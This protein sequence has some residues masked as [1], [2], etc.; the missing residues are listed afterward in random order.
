[1]YYGQRVLIESGFGEGAAVIA[2]IAP[3]V[4][5]VVGGV[6]ALYNMDRID[7]RKTFIIGLSLTTTCHLLIGVASMLLPSGNAL[8]PW[9]TLILVVAFVASMQAF[10]NIA[11]WVWLAEIFP[12]H[13][14]AC[15]PE[16]LHTSRDLVTGEHP[17]QRAVRAAAADQPRR[18]GPARGRAGLPRIGAH[19]LRH[20]L[21]SDLLRAGNSLPQIGQVLRHRSQLSTAIYAK[22]D[23]ARLRDA[24]RP[25][26]STA[27]TQ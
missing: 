11:V 15:V 22:V 17:R 26:P 4:V 12:L 23:T 3:G 10:L 7:R 19:R 8:R 13:T 9:V 24:A 5:A 6:I 20:T 1:M 18:A 27:V 16:R 14:R 2:N 25:W 21:A